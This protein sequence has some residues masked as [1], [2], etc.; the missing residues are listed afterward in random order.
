MGQRIVF[1]YL[2][3]ANIGCTVTGGHVS[4]LRPPPTIGAAIIFL[5]V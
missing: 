2:V 3:H 1:A 4:K 5:A